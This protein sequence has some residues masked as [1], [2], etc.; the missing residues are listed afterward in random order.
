MARNRASA[1]QAGTRFEREIADYLRD[2]LGDGRIDRRIKSGAKDR[3]D[4]AGVMIHGRRL[5]I[6]AKDYGGRFLASGW[7]DEMEIE[8]GNDDALAGFVI[9][10]RKGTTDPGEQYVLTT[11]REMVAI[12]G[13]AR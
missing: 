5:V 13:G 6:E 9:V 7:V 10:K 8:R 11:V 3:G 2:V 12:I 4:I 1:K